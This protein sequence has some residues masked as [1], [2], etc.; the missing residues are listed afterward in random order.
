[1]FVRDGTSARSGAAS[2]ARAGATRAASSRST[3]AAAAGGPSDGVRDSDRGAN[4]IATAMPPTTTP[5]ATPHRATDNIRCHRSRRRASS[6]LIVLGSRPLFATAERLLTR[7]QERLEVVDVLVED[8]VED[9]AP[10]GGF[11]TEAEGDERARE[12]ADLALRVHGETDPERHEPELPQENG[13]GL[14]DPH[15]RVDVNGAGFTG[16]RGPLE[17]AP[18][19]TPAFDGQLARVVRVEHAPEKL[20]TRPAE[21]RIDEVREDDGEIAVGL[22]EDDLRRPVDGNDGPWGLGFAF[23]VG[24]YAVTSRGLPAPWA[25]FERSQRA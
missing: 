13:P 25:S 19:R 11:V 16:G 24:T 9:L 3:G 20:V 6:M 23:H 8:R 21:V 22:L 12:D 4:A 1:M 15:A 7:E 17:R 14:V 5:A 18:G 2:S 10:E